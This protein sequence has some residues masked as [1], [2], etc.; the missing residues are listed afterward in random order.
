M[1]KILLA[2]DDVALAIT[3]KDWLE[4]E[5]NSVDAVKD[6]A[7]ALENLLALD[8]DVAI[9]DWNLPKMTGIEI[10]Q[11]YRAKGGNTPILLLTGKNSVKE[12][13][14]GLDS[15]ADDYLTKPFHPKELAAR[16]RAMIRRATGFLP[17]I[18]NAGP[19]SLDRE[20]R[21]VLRD[22]KPVHLQPMEY[23]LLEFFMKHPNQ[24]FSPETLLH[25]LWD[26][27]SEVSLDAIYTCIR[28]LRKKLDTPE[29]TD[30]IIRTVHGVGYGINPLY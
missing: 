21:I 29:S 13:E 5:N 24:V 26:A 6:G 28:R 2:E 4:F 14:E 7:S 19:L 1:A 12:K 3:I 20:K 16:L 30:S 22:G 27:N 18:V 10:C 15:G 25:K 17:E 9:I 8:Y 23:T 11:K